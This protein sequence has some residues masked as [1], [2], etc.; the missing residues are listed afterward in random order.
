L[1]EQRP[2]EVVDVNMGGQPLARQV[3]IGGRSFAHAVWAQPTADRGTSQISYRLNGRAGRLHG[4][5]G[6]VDATEGA[7]AEVV[8]PVAVFRIYGDGNLL[9]ESDRLSGRGAAQVLDVAVA[10]IDLLALV[11]ESES[12]AAVSAVAWGDLQL[13]SKGASP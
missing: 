4:V 13:Q 5:V 12:A 7:G 10:R 8:V 6:I 2:W 11:C 3:R 9:W 1:A